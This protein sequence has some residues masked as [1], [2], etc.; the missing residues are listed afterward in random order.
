MVIKRDEYYTLTSLI[1]V[2]ACVSILLIY[3]YGCN[4]SIGVAF[5]INSPAYLIAIFGLI[6]TGRTFILDQEGCTVLFWKYRK[7]YTWGELK[8]K[9]I[10]SHHL[11]SML[12]GR[13]T[14]PYLTEAIFSPYR[15]HKPKLIRAGLYSL[16][17]PFSC[18][19]INFSNKDANY[20]HGRYYEVEEATFRQKM[21][22]WGVELEEL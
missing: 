13:Y 1:G 20:Q 5:M 11:P 3:V 9:R 22:E 12:R 16:F 4:L 7:K 17:H 2:F 18:I 6:A 8:T 15:I 10:E 19:Y 21:K 14:C